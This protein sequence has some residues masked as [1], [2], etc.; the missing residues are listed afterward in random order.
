MQSINKER[1]EVWISRMLEL[2]ILSKKSHTIM[3]I[4]KERF[5]TDDWFYQIKSRDCYKKPLTSY[6]IGS[7]KKRI[8]GREIERQIEN[9]RA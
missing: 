5:P 6:Y 1:D 2:R 3:R 8:K 4:L 9:K 7:L